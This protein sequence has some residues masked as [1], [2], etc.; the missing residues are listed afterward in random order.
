MTS[1]AQTRNET[2][3]PLTDELAKRWSPR[4]FDATYDVSAED[5]TALGEAARWAPSANNSQPARYIVARR[6]TPTFT[7]ITDTL[8]A[9][10]RTWAPRASVLIVALAE[11]E[12]DGKPLRWAEYDLGQSVA[13]LSVEAT[14]RGLNVRQMGGF[15]PDKLRR[16]FDLPPTLTPV[17]V[18]AI[19]RYDDSPDVPDEVRE[20]DRAARRRRGLEDLAFIL[21]V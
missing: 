11:T 16:S 18:I 6:G 13:H 10:N 21:E 5:L 1:S 3:V 17:T 7:R 15:L 14:A 9:F 4:G 8:M 19:G 20:R 12:R 2:S